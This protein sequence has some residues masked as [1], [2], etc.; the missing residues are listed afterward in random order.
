M[1]KE[2]KQFCTECRKETEYEIRKRQ[3]VYSIRGKEYN[4]D[5]EV[6]ICKECG[7]EVY[8][9]GLMDRN[10]KL[11]DEQ[12]RKAEDLVSIDDI[13]ALM[14]VYNIGKA[15]VSLALGF[16]EIT[17]TRYLQGQYPSAEYSEVIHE[18]LSNPDFMLDLLKKN[19]EKIGETAFKKSYSAAMSLKELISSVSE[20]MLLT[21]SYIFERAEEVTP[22]ALQ[23]LLYYIQGV[24]MVNYGKVLFDEDCQAWDYGPVFSKVYNLFSEFKYNPI[25]DKRF[26]FFKNKSQKLSKEEKKVIDM[27]INSF[28]MYSGKT[29]ANI[30]HEESP[31]KD[32]HEEKMFGYSNVKITKKAIRDYFEKEAKK[33]DFRTEKGLNDYIKYQLEKRK[34]YC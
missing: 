13:K 3:C 28:G 16:G 19:R 14:E 20:K 32:A 2:K 18:A 23:K 8:L 7:E 24:Y 33:Y 9:P 1:R 12:Y 15:P 22:L 34:S 27:V 6:A 10:S 11:I 31:W 25:E 29:L 17:I 26:I 21:I 5:I 30:T 4:F